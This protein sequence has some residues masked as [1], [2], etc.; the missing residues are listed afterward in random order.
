MLTP[1]K[2]PTQGSGE[3]RKRLEENHPHGATIEKPRNTS[4]KLPNEKLKM[5]AT[6]KESTRAR[7]WPPSTEAE[8]HFKYD[9]EEHLK[10]RT[11]SEIGLTAR[12]LAT[13][14]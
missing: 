6:P 3:R 1:V 9:I 12:A 11:L 7:P 14:N 8:T 10:P 2:T 13:A 4:F 5:P